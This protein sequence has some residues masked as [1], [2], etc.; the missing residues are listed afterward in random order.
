MQ[1]VC[2][3]AGQASRNAVR[4]TAKLSLFAGRLGGRSSCTVHAVDR[5]QQRRHRRQV[6]QRRFG[7]LAEGRRG[8]LI[9]QLPHTCVWSGRMH[10]AIQTCSTLAAVYESSDVPPQR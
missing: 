3:S 6:S 7:C 9:V 10:D 4:V 1:P 5:T 2:G 8:W